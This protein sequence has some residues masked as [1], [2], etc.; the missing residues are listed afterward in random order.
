V[1]DF[2]RLIGDNRGSK[3]SRFNIFGDVERVRFRIRST[4]SVNE[5]FVRLA[6]IDL[7]RLRD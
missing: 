7:E 5:E 1:T 4:S 3:V 6:F 2:D